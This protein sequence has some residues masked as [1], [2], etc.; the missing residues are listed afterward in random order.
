MMVHSNRHTQNA[1]SISEICANAGERR[2]VVCTQSFI[3][4]AETRGRLQFQLKRQQQ[5]DR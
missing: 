1:H 5:F 3:H 2:A 4:V